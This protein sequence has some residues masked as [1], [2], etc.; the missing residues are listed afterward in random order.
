VDVYD[1][2]ER[3]TKNS[4]FKENYKDLTDI[5]K[6]LI[7][8]KQKLVINQKTSHVFL[9]DFY[10]EVPHANGISLF[11]PTEESEDPDNDLL[12]LE[13]MKLYNET[14]WNKVIELLTGGRVAIV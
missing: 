4:Y 8:T 13:N 12:K 10:L 3:L 5:A 11:M 1:F 9:K 6:D 14:G 7:K 2:C